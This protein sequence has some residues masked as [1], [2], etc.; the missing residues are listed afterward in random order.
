VSNLFLLNP[1]ATEIAH[2]D[3]AV[4]Q[5]AFGPPSILDSPTPPSCES[6]MLVVDQDGYL[7]PIF[8]AGDL[9]RWCKAAWKVERD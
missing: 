3:A 9:L 6:V 2:V 8:T 4:A 1:T 5:P 7:A